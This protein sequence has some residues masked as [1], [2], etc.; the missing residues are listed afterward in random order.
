MNATLIAKS[1][2]TNY[3]FSVEY[4]SKKYD[5]IVWV[6]EKGKFDDTEVSLNGEI[7]DCEGDEGEANEA[8]L[9]YLDENWD[10]LV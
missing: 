8:I 2:T 4:N 3:S 6:N 10:R 5:V 1:T 9:N 7:L